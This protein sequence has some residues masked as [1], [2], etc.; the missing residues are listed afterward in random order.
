[1]GLFEIKFSMNGIKVN[2][3]YFLR[4]YLLEGVSSSVITGRSG[5]MF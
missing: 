2:V 3:G 4:L 1:M 5:N